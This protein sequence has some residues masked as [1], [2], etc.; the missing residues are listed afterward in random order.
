MTLVVEQLAFLFGTLLVSKLPAADGIAYCD[1]AGLDDIDGSQ[2]DQC[3]PCFDHDLM[4][5]P[6]ITLYC[7]L[8]VLRH[9][10]KARE[11]VVTRDAHV[12]EAEPAIVSIV[13]T[14]LGAEVTDLDARKGHMV[15]DCSY[16]YNKW[17]HA[18]VTAVYNEPSKYNSVS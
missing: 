15:L 10:D 13:E 17:F 14:K 4:L 8:A 11:D 7:D 16:L 18:V 5:D 1:D 9:F 6:W 12:V 3:H 2:K